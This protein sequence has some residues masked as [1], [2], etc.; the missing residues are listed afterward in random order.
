MSVR[1]DCAFAART[2]FLAAV[3]SLGQNAACTQ[4]QHLAL[5]Q[6]HRRPA[7]EGQQALAALSFITVFV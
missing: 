4:L 5:E 2:D 6:Q 1:N 3:R 7:D